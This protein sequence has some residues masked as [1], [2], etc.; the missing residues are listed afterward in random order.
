VERAGKHMQAL[1]ALYP[2]LTINTDFQQYNREKNTTQ[3]EQNSII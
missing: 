2:Q 3:I 1:S